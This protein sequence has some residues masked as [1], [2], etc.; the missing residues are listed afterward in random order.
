MG[1][2]EEYIIEIKISKKT[3]VIHIALEFWDHP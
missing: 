2:Y 3:C 1:K